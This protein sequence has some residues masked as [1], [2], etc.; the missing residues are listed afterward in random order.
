MPGWEM[1]VDALRQLLFALAHHMNG[2]L[3]GSIAAVAAV[4][5]VLLLPLTVRAALAARDHQ[6]RLIRLKPQLDALKT[7]HAGKSGDLA[8]AT[9]A[10]YKAHDIPALPKG[11]L[12]TALVQIPLGAAIYQAVRTGLTTGTRF[13]WI[14]DLTKPDVALTAVVGALAALGVGM[15]GAT[16]PSGANAAGVSTYVMAVGSGLMTVF[17]AFRLASGIGIY[18]AASSAVGILQ[19]VIVRRILRSRERAVD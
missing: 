9:A 10:L 12:I 7:R 3:G 2:S 8:L 14:G 5:R 6:A 16:Q 11:T 4:A 17:F 13:L 19:P 15:T 1:L 18:W